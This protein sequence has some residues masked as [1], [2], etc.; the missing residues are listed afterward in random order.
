MIQCSQ[1]EHFVQGPAGQIGFTCNPFSNIKEPE[2]LNKWQ[3]VKLDLLVR[4]YQSTLEMYNR[5]APLQEKMFRHMQRE[6]EDMEESD[7]WK[8][9]EDEDEEQS[10]DK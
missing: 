6:V 1:C 9:E 10:E 3:L 7:S 2:C 5:L 8:C 4:A